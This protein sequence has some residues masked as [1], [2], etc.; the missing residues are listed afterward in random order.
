[1]S[2]CIL[3][4]YA[5]YSNGTFYASNKGKNWMRAMIIGCFV[6]PLLIVGF[7]SGLIMFAMVWNSCAAVSVDAG[8][9]I[10]ALMFFIYVPLYVVGTLLGRNL[11]KDP[12]YPCKVNPVDNPILKTKQWYSEPGFLIV[13][14]GLLPFA[15]MSVEIHFIFTA[16]WSYKVYYSF[17]FAAAQLGL[18]ILCIS[19][20]SITVTY[21]LLNS[22]DARW[23]WVSFLSGGST[24]LYFSMYSFFF[25]LFKT[26]MTGFF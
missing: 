2:Y 26:N 8:S 19:C 21:V 15:N 13:A 1:M 4:V 14:G 17:A 9:K 11:A 16:I 25:Y 12:T 20:V 3:G 22:E 7:E 18:L 24:A 5:G 23:A 6:C 10:L